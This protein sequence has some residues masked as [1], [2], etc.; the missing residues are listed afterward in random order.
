MTTAAK[1][2]NKMILNRIYDLAN[3]KIDPNQAGFRKGM[4]TTTQIHILRRIIEGFK[5]KN[6]P[7]TMIFV[8]FTKSRPLRGSRKRDASKLAKYWYRL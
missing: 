2:Y 6:L 7:L 5:L 4:S 1:I 8:D 3:Q